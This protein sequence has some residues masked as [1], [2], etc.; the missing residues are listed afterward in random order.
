MNYKSKLIDKIKFE[1]KSIN[2]NNNFLQMKFS[3]GDTKIEIYGKI[4]I[5]Q[6]KLSKILLS[7]KKDEWPT[8]FQQ[9]PGFF[10]IKIIRN[11]KITILNDIFGNYRLYYSTIDKKFIIYD[12]Y[13]GKNIDNKFEL[14]F[15]KKKSYT[16]PFS[17][18]DTK[19]NKLFPG[20]IL[21]FDNFS[22]NIYD[23]KELVLSKKSDPNK[24][25]SLSKFIKSNLS[26]VKN[27]KSKKNILF[28]SGGRDS[29]YLSKMLDELS[30]DH[31]LCFIVYV[32]HFNK[33]NI[34]DLIKS[35]KLA[36]LLDKK[37]DIIEFSEKNYNS[38]IYIAQKTKPIDYSFPAMYH[39]VSRL[40]AKYGNFNIING[41]SSDSL[42]AWGITGKGFSSV[43]Q[44]IIISE[45]Y[46]NL[47]SLLKLFI[48][49][50]LSF[51]YSLKIYKNFNYYIPVNKKEFVVAVNCPAIYVPLYRNS[52]FF[53]KLRAKLE[54]HFVNNYNDIIIAKLHYLQGSSNQLVIGSGM[55]QGLDVF[56]PF[57]DPRI[58]L[59][60]RK[61][62]KLKTILKPRYEIEKYFN[63]SELEILNSKNKL[64]KSDIVKTYD[65]KSKWIKT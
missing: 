38:A 6:I 51:I 44:R 8:F 63:K 48:S 55:G 35:R 10:V 59:E 9:L 25:Y 33:D 29:L 3:V 17:T 46:Y 18:F 64:T 50:P 52:D 14:E 30:I 47:P 20:A 26:F 56:M 12:K 60:V 15:F 43:I 65:F 40:K 4:N 27:N 1:S 31:I 2:L 41:Q 28:F 23:N 34:E 11:E 62:N 61:K 32:D 19:I 49:L 39:A 57:L 54:K 16:T 7:I 45:F 36:K 37:L 13:P 5:D 24:D 58:I 21:I 22:L 53:K 42:L